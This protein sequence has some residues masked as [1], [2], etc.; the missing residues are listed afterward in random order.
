VIRGTTE[1]HRSHEKRVRRRAAGPVT[2]A[3]GAFPEETVVVI[4]EPRLEGDD[5]SYTVEVLD[6]TVPAETGPVSLFIDPFGRPLSPVSLAGINRGQR[7][8]AR[9]RF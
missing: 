6:G 4:S 7:R 3:S 9:R 2:N 5:L 1:I 8:R